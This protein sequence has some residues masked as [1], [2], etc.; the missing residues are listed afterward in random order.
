MLWSPRLKAWLVTRHAD[1]R[2]GFRDPRLSSDRIRPFLA[3]V[4]EG[5]RA[6]VGP[7]CEGLNRW[8]VFSDPPRHAP[9]RALVGQAFTVNA[10]VSL[11][12]QITA[13]VDRLLDE[14]VQDHGSLDFH[15]RFAYP[16]PALV[17]AH[18]VGVPAS[19]LTRLKAWSDGLAQFVMTS[20]SDPE[21]HR[22]A[23]A[24]FA[25]M[26]AY[27]DAFVRRRAARAD[28]ADLTSSMLEAQRLDPTLTHEDIVANLMAVLFAGHETTTTLLT[29]GLH[30]L[31]KHPQALQLL[32]DSEE[33][34]AAVRNLVEELLRYE[35]PAL[36][37]ARIAATDFEWHGK[38]IRAGERVFLVQA[39]ANRDP[40]VFEDPDRFDVSRSN[41]IE[42]LTFGFG[43][44][45][46][47]GSQLAR[48]EARIA[49][50]RLAKRCPGLSLTDA[51]PQWSDAFMTR[52]LREL[53]VTV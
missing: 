41:A 24:G 51:P 3:Q 48:S 20:R 27:F 10:V 32:R 1:V 36:S 7:L 39:A 53:R 49:L 25:E 34:S 30:T 12:P 47:A 46:C 35:G 23:A 52:A 38:A 22:R 13:L 43:I 6:I 29:N 11:R 19:D 16:L 4:T 18:M 40:R 42:H 26:S 31:L 33:D 17:I 5:L 28:G 15:R 9:L 45:F 8:Q 37:M 2:T 21:R 44:H 50:S 14:T